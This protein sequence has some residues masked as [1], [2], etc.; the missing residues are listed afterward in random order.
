MLRLYKVYRFCG[1]YRAEQENNRPTDPV[2]APTIIAIGHPQ[3]CS[4]I[5][6][7]ALHAGSLWVG[8][9]GLACR[10]MARPAAYAGDGPARS[11]RRERKPYM[12]VLEDLSMCAN[13]PLRCL[14]KEWTCY[15]QHD[16][17]QVRELAEYPSVLISSD[18]NGQRYRWFLCV[19]D[20]DSPWLPGPN[21]RAIRTHV[22]LAKRSRERC[23]VVIKF[24]HPWGVTVAGPASYALEARRL[25]SDNQP[26][27]GF[28]R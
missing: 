19:V 26:S 23:F 17:H 22:R 21:V 8:R 6:T 24:G 4:S 15:L 13:E 20:D 14:V 2:D 18:R 11:A 12:V 25:I 27:S 3:P 5:E 1:G 10:L 9:H 28:F 16:G 7:W